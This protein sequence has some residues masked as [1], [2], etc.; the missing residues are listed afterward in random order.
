[1]LVPEYHVVAAYFVSQKLCNSAEDEKSAGTRPLRTA[2]ALA[3]A[4]KTTK[5]NME[6]QQK[7]Q[8]SEQ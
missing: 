7:N 6:K 5:A 1:M 4:K 8:D 3:V 2:F